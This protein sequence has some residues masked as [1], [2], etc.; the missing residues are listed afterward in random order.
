MQL[1]K[2]EKEGFKKYAGLIMLQAIVEELNGA[3]ATPLELSVDCH[4]QCSAAFQVSTTCAKSSLRFI[5]RR[6]VVFRKP[7]SVPSLWNAS[8]KCLPSRSQA[9]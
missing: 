8:T 5:D 3:T 2:E 6:A 9:E 7:I 4:K 1:I